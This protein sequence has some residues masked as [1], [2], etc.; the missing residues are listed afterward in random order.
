[1]GDP[2]LVVRSCAEPPPLL[3]TGRSCPPH[4]PHQWMPP[5]PP[6]PH[7]WMPRTPP[8]Q[9]TPHLPPPL[10]AGTRG[11]QGNQLPGRRVCVPTV[12]DGTVLVFGSVPSSPQVPA[13]QG[14]LRVSGS[15]C[16]ALG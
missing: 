14:T 12:P 11:P 16:L 8:H 7:Q 2:V 3:V 9:W 4:P 13:E 10:D 15:L 6:H 1:M 5:P